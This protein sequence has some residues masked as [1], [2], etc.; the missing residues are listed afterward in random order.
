MQNLN[1]QQNT[2][3]QLEKN[4]MFVTTI[5]DTF[6]ALE[7]TLGKLKLEKPLFLTYIAKKAFAEEVFKYAKQSNRIYLSPDKKNNEQHIL[8]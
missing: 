6:E 2:S 3:S 8:Q 1:T 7:E 4:I 5:Y